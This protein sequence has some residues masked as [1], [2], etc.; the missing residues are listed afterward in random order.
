MGNGIIGFEANRILERDSSAIGLPQTG[1]GHAQ[2]VARQWIIRLEAHSGLQSTECFFK[3]ALR[4]K[5]QTQVAVSVGIIGILGKGVVEVIAHNIRILGIA[6]QHTPSAHPVCISFNRMG[7]FAKNHLPFDIG[8]TEIN[9]VQEAA[10]HA[11][12]KG[13]Q[14][15][16]RTYHL[17]QFQNIIGISPQNAGGDLDLVFLQPTGTV[18]HQCC[19][20]RLANLHGR[21]IFRQS[22]IQ[23]IGINH[24]QC[25]HAAE[26]V[27]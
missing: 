26:L 7:G 3:P 12:L 2:I 25:R 4:D 8:S 19:T 5:E 17:F 6:R 15:I 9:N 10:N 23:P 13:K 21:L 18:Q 16:E 24:L 22:G 20:C 27:R 14:G 11:V 1:I